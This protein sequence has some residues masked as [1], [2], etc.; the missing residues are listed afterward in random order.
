MSQDEGVR[1]P[2]D[3]IWAMVGD[4]GESLMKWGALLVST[5]CSLKVR[6]I[7]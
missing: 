4:L 3:R 7:L 5:G 2:S 1:K 6:V